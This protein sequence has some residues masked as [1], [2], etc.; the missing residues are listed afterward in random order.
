MRIKPQPRIYASEGVM[1]WIELVVRFLRILALSSVNERRMPLNRRFKALAASCLLVL[2][3]GL[4]AQ[5]TTK[6]SEQPSQQPKTAPATESIL[7]SYE[8]QNVTGVEIAG[9]PGLDTTKL[10]PL[11][12][13][14]AGEPF[15]R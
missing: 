2:S 10:T 11:F 6:P 7:S 12:Q 3:T 8:G 1:E 15:S 5:N 13:Q 9:R 14:H 4:R